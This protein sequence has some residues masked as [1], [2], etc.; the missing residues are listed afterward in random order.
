ML[1]LSH[2]TPSRDSSANSREARLVLMLQKILL[3]TNVRLF[4]SRHYSARP[5]HTDAG[6]VSQREIE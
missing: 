1:Q 2:E 5:T 6:A 4:L 3:S